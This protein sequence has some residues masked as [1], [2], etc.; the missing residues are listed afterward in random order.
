MDT[1]TQRRKEVGESSL[2]VEKQ[3]LDREMW[4]VKVKKDG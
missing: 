3:R 2:G 4:L 1:S